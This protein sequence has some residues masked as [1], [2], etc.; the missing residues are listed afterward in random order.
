[1]K[2]YRQGRGQ[3]PL[4]VPDLPSKEEYDL[5]YQINWGTKSYPSKRLGNIDRDRLWVEVI[6]IHNSKSLE[7]RKWVSRFLIGL[8]FAQ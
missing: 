3:R 4:E 7:D 2:K 8:G 6:K 1:M 5:A